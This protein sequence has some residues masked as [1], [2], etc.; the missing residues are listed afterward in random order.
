MFSY[1]RNQGSAGQ[2]SWLVL[3]VLQGDKRTAEV[4]LLLSVGHCQPQ[5]GLYI[6]AEK[7]LPP[8]KH[9]IKWDH[10]S[11]LSNMTQDIRMTGQSTYVLYGNWHLDY[12][13]HTSLNTLWQLHIYCCSSPVWGHVY[14]MEVLLPLY[15]ASFILPQLF[16]ATHAFCTCHFRLTFF[17]LICWILVP[18]LFLCSISL[19]LVCKI[20][21]SNF[22]CCS[23]TNQ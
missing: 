21:L 23:L 15:T 1:Q 9:K 5:R 12:I 20:F 22:K 13:T 17:L 4:G 18:V 10:I 14:V 3:F 11:I 19:G 7:A 2:K 6:P 16:Q 8:C